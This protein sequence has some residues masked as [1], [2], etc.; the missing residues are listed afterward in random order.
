MAHD[1]RH[2]IQGVATLWTANTRRPAKEEPWTGRLTFS[3]EPKPAGAQ[4]LKVGDGV[5]LSSF[6]TQV[7]VTK[8]RGGY[9]LSIDG[10]AVVPT[11]AAGTIPVAK[12][13]RFRGPFAS[14]ETGKVVIGPVAIALMTETGQHAPPVAYV[15][16]VQQTS[17][18]HRSIR[19]DLVGS[20]E[21]NS[22]SVQD[23]S[24][25]VTSTPFPCRFTESPY[26]V[27]DDVYNL[28]IFQ[29][30]KASRSL[31]TLL[32]SVIT[33]LYAVYVGTAVLIPV[34]AGP[35][36][37]LFPEFVQAAA[38]GAAG[39]AAGA[40]S[41]AAGA[42]SAAAGAAGAVVPPQ[43]MTQ[44]I[45][46]MRD[47]F[48]RIFSG[49]GRA[50]TISLVSS[51]GF[52][53]ETAQAVDVLGWMLTF[54][55]FTQLSAILNKQNIGLRRTSL[56]I[57]DQPGGL[58]G[59]SDDANSDASL[60][61][62]VQLF[63]NV[64]GAVLQPRDSKDPP[65][66]KRKF[67]LRG[68]AETLENLM[69]IDND[70]QNNPE[71]RINDLNRVV[72]KR[73][74]SESVLADYLMEPEP[75]I[76]SQL[77]DT[78]N[79]FFAKFGFGFQNK[80]TR[81]NDPKGT[82]F[83][84]VGPADISGLDP[85]LLRKSYVGTT[86]EIYVIDPSDTNGGFR[87][88]L[89]AEENV[90][91]QAGFHASGVADDMDLLESTLIRF[92][93]VHCT[94]QST[95]SSWYALQNSFLRMYNSKPED[96]GWVQ[97]LAQIQR[98]TRERICIGANK[99]RTTL[100]EGY[101]AKHLY[102]EAQYDVYGAL[103]PPDKRKS[104]LP[105]LRSRHEQAPDIFVVVQ[106]GKKLVLR[107]FPQRSVYEAVAAPTFLRSAQIGVLTITPDYEQIHT[108]QP[109]DSAIEEAGRWTRGYMSS[110]AT[111]N[112]LFEARSETRTLWFHGYIVDKDVYEELAR[113]RIGRIGVDRVS[114][115]TDSVGFPLYVQDDMQRCVVPPFVVDGID[116]ISTVST[117][118]F[119]ATAKEHARLSI[120]GTQ[121]E[122]NVNTTEP[123]SLA[124]FLAMRAVAD[125]LIARIIGRSQTVAEPC[126]RGALY[127]LRRSLPNVITMIKLVSIDSKQGFSGVLGR[128]DLLFS[129]LPGGSDAARLLN[130]VGA[131]KRDATTTIVANKF[132]F[133]NTLAQRLAN[134]NRWPTEADA[135]IREIGSTLTTIARWPLALSSIYALQNTIAVRD[136]E[137]G[138]RSP[139]VVVRVQEALGSVERAK[140]L[141]ESLGIPENHLNCVVMRL[142]VHWP[143]F[144]A[145]RRACT[146]QDSFAAYLADLTPLDKLPLRLLTEQSHDETTR[147]M[148]LRNATLRLDTLH[149][150]LDP[151]A[152]DTTAEQ[153]S[154]E[155]ARLSF[156]TLSATRSATYFV[157]FAHGASPLSRVQSLFHPGSKGLDS[158]P[159]WTDHLLAG[160]QRST[161]HALLVQNG[162]TP[163]AALILGPR[164]P[165]QGHV[166]EVKAT[167]TTGQIERVSCCLTTL[168]TP[169]NLGTVSSLVP[170][171]IVKAVELTSGA[172]PPLEV[173]SFV[174]LLVWNA[175]RL[176]QATLIAIGQNAVPA[177]SWLSCDPPEKPTRSEP[178]VD[179]SNRCQQTKL[180]RLQ[181]LRNSVAAHVI[182]L[183][184]AY[185]AA[186]GPELKDFVERTR[187]NNQLQAG[188]IRSP[189]NQ[190]TPMAPPTPGE[191]AALQQN[192]N[193]TQ[194]TGA[195]IQDYTDQVNIIEMMTDD[196]LVEARHRWARMQSEPRLGDNWQDDQSVED[197]AKNFDK[198]EKM[199]KRHAIRVR[200]AD[201]EIQA[202]NLASD[203]Q[204]IA[205]DIV[206][207]GGGDT[208]DRYGTYR[209]EAK[210]RMVAG[211]YAKAVT[212]RMTSEQEARERNERLEQ[213]KDMAIR[214]G[215]VAFVCSVALADSILASLLGEAVAP[216]LLARSEDQGKESDLDDARKRVAAWDLRPT[217]QPNAASLH[218]VALLLE[219]R[220]R[221]VTL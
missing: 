162:N 51:V 140:Q 40:A 71:N 138:V 24:I 217:A 160:I 219:Q 6:Q 104:S 153:I 89:E 28:R 213:T 43:A 169:L 189:L 69:A 174:D 49:S 26:I 190:I 39:A 221:S 205:V 110:M 13:K 35:I 204:E 178:L 192:M 80:D 54:M 121:Q 155:L 100:F 165:A 144:L 22:G 103:S 176:V 70:L 106:P 113:Q 7:L 5:D 46:L 126:V 61:A 127:S 66:N 135:T 201:P 188:P 158:V 73:Y 18:E 38:S 47:W 44:T 177:R 117:T 161:E 36:S 60:N 84:A 143:V 202:L 9:E 166:F 59:S 105:E 62:R 183:K 114:F 58:G 209:A 57:E 15:N 172:D 133:D 86:I 164:D 116:Q 118:G 95:M 179:D 78:L 200:N 124:E 120:G 8:T 186:V 77:G 17:I 175:E 3:N 194:Q 157:P 198:F 90:A 180:R 128:N 75:G 193:L 206:F 203:S 129:C 195:A 50:G 212:G 149:D 109:I 67:T 4:S 34:F 147:Y 220:V 185:T 136:I 210:L 97:T 25:P 23:Q 123:A 102:D 191:L 2:D 134:Y 55:R 82:F 130:T 14:P 146:D 170:L 33:F 148:R 79:R 119:S 187:A 131:W 182:S 197:Y 167:S 12:I 111:L 173:G 37:S 68:L 108:K 63:G 16:I 52:A 163:E 88:R 93:A 29:A 98:V 1:T 96:P 91:F 207:Q 20:F 151:A 196:T 145:T 21:L 42:A 139:S 99:L 101:T 74:K 112:R 65:R 83:A 87:V 72:R 199:V 30:E 156:D 76:V 171:S 27:I 85:D 41:A 154:T 94:Q 81:G 92:E 132:Q 181:S 168:M 211:Q 215:A 214:Q 11:A 48:G 107:M 141:S 152:G 53:V 31:M 32:N 218:E 208:V 125:M 184:H 115:A 10:V 216:K 159:V 137:L 64:A 45:I 150:Q 122:V 19:E 56:G 142:V